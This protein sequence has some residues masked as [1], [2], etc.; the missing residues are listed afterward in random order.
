MQPSL[1]GP[2]LNSNPAENSDD[3]ACSESEVAEENCEVSTKF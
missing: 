2:G 1:G 3:D